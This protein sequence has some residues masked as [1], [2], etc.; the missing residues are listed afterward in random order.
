MDDI[1]NVMEDL[2]DVNKL[3]ITKEKIIDE[4]NK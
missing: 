1:N 3:K 4:R 2:T